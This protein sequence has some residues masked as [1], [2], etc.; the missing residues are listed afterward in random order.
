MGALTRDQIVT[1]GLGKAGNLS[2]ALRTRIETEFQA[3]LD[4]QYSAW[5][6]PFLKKRAVGLSLSS[7]AT[8]LTI[9]A[10]SGGVTLEIIRLVSPI[11]FYTTD[12]TT[13]GKAPLVQVAGS[14]SV[15]FDETLQ[16]SATWIGTP[17]SFKARNGTVRGRWDLIPMPFPDRALNIAIDYY[18]R[19]AALGAST[20]PIYPEDATMIQ[21]VNALAL[22]D[23]KGEDSP[24]AITAND[25]T[26][27]MLARDRSTHGQ[28]PG[29]ND[30]LQLDSSVFK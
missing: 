1:A 9:G 2:T 30:I 25:R 5:S 11:L 26:S 19:P 13:V 16:N 12:R 10:G 29:E 24:A 6:W 28:V 15:Q 20:V 27:N 3:W 21:A 17:T 14:N 7:G 8:S 18:E 23:Q 22:V 4:R